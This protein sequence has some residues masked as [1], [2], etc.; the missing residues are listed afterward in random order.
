[1]EVEQRLPVVK[2]LPHILGNDHNQVIDVVVF[3]GR[4]P[5]A[6]KKKVLELGQAC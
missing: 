1:M 3:V 6:K 2:V 5:C 4:D